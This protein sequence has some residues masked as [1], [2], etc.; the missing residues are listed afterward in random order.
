MTTNK[1]EWRALADYPDYEMNN[2]G[3]VRKIETRKYLS[4]Y[5]D[6]LNRSLVVFHNPKGAVSEY[7]SDL[8]AMTFGPVSGQVAVVKAPELIAIMPE[9]EMVEKPR[10]KRCRRIRCIE[11]GEVFKSYTACAN[12]FGF[13]Y[14]KFYDTFKATGRFD[15][16][17]FEDVTE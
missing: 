16:Y 9:P 11:T 5:K 3:K 10:N 12:H 14:D 2:E 7:I 17:T 1:M 13:P 15:E 4:V 8:M 6:R